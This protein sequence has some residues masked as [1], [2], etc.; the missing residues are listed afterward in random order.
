MTQYF[1]NERVLE[2]LEGREIGGGVGHRADVGLADADVIVESRSE[3]FA[4][5]GSS[6]DVIGIP[7]NARIDLSGRDFTIRGQ[8]IVSDRGVDGSTGALL[9]TTD[10]GKDSPAWDGGSSGRGVI[11][12]RGGSRISGVRFRGPYHDHY[13]DPEYP[14]YIPLDSGT[15]SERRRKRERRYARGM[16]ILHDDVEV[17]NC[18]LYGWP[19]QAMAIGASS[20]AVSPHVHHVYGHDCMMVGA[21]YV[22]DVFN[23]HPTIELSYFNATRH[24]VNGFGFPTCGYTL[25]D[26][27]FGPSTYSHAVDMHCLAENG[28]SGDLTAGGRVEVRRCT[29]AFTHSIRGTNCQAI[30]FRGYP[31]DRYVTDDNRFLHAVDGSFENPANTGRQPVP[32][33]QVNVGSGWHGWY[34]SGNQYG[35]GERH[36]SGIG[37][38]IN[39]D[40]P[41]DGKPL[42][43]EERRRALRAALTTLES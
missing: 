34:A 5:L 4:A 37:A 11:T 38:P 10:H 15:A 29:F 9:Y 7:G 20:T 26:C 40:D 16:R 43:D 13:D 36:R 42:V 6:A 12:M 1:T 8:T 19:N 2:C 18:E 24:S 23:G 3:F 39:L 35:V 41:M 27:V 32:Y 30:A 17:D 25:E 21:G 22:V 14:G 28:Y 31:D 33:R